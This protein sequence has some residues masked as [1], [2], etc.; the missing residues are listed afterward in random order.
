MKLYRHRGGEDDGAPGGSGGGGAERG[1]LKGDGSICYARPESV[2]LAVQLLDESHFRSDGSARLSVQRAKFEQRGKSYDKAQDRSRVSDAKRKVARL[3]ALQAVNWD[4]EGEGGRISGGR[5]GL[6]IIVLKGVFAPSEL[7]G[8]GSTEKE[9]NDA[10][11]RV[12]NEVHRECSNHGTVEKITIFSKNPRGVVVVKF[13]Q[14]TA[15]SDAVDALHGRSWGEK[16]ERRIEASYWDGVTDYTI[17]DEE[18]EIKEEDTRHDEFGKWLEDQE[19][20]PEEFKL[21]VEG[22]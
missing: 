11:G 6:R 1:E 20:L 16:G 13:A 22:Q 10:I 8:D 18:R 15:A 14:P 5:K 9:E 17:R 19:D 21:K 7:L 12:E 3:A 4:E 2:D